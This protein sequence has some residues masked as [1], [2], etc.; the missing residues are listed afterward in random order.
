MKKLLL[1]N[2]ILISIATATTLKVPS[3]YSTIQAAIVVSSNGDTVLVQPGTYVENINYN[4]KNIVVGSLILTTGDTSYISQTVIDGDSSDSVVT[5]KGGENSA[6]KLN[7]FTITN[8]YSNSG[9]GIFFYNSSP[10]IFN[11]KIIGNA[12]G[13][14]GGGIYCSNSNPIFFRESKFK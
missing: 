6:A 7:G 8:G 4:G 11:T 12:S 3:Q 9:G 14:D 1:S 5:F 2:L 13:N 10:S